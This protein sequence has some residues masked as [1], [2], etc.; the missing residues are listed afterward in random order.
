MFA[1]EKKKARLGRMMGVL[2]S[3]S[4]LKVVDRGYSIVTKKNEV[5]KSA[6]QVKV[7]DHLDIRLAEGSLTAVVDGVKE[8]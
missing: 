6:S 3:L 1:L 4:P 2:D 8:K 7:G 5:I